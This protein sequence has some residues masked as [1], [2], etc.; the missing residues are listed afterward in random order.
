MGTVSNFKVLKMKPVMVMISI[1]NLMMVIALMIMIILLKI[2]II[3]QSY[4]LSFS[5]PSFS[6]LPLSSSHPSLLPLTNLL[7]F[8]SSAY[9]P[10]PLI[11]K[12]KIWTPSYHRVLRTSS[13]SSHTR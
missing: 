10:L 8:P 9:S 11:N 4:T 13:P 6:C 12:D 1:M 5:L 3:I 7:P 2:K